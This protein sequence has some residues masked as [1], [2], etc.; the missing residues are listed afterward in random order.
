MNI[1]KDKFINAVKF[2]LTSTYFTFNGII[3]K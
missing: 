3:Y 2:V 1:S